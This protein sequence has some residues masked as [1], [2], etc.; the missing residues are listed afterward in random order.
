MN[1]AEF[2]KELKDSIRILDDSEQQYFVEEYTQHID[3]KMSQGMSEE[4]A[5]GEMGS[6]KELSREILESYHVKVDGEKADAEPPKP[7]FLSE[8]KTQSDKLYGNIAKALRKAGQCIKAFFVKVDEKQKEKKLEKAEAQKERKPF[9]E[10]FLPANIGEDKSKFGI[11]KA[12]KILLHAIAYCI[13]TFFYAC[14]Y[15]MIFL[16]NVCCFCIGLFFAACLA[17]LIF[18]IG[19]LFVMLTQGYPVIGMLVGALG[20]ALC[21]GAVIVTCF[22]AVRSTHRVKVQEGGEA[23]A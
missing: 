7:P 3:M 21:A 4:E 11:G 20:A 13:K 18:M 22:I 2:I 19:L 14:V 9:K 12:I 17:F 15:V 5:V 10:R 1:K 8:V 16:W 6:I 23:N